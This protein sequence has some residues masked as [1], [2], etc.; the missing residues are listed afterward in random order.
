MQRR[1]RTR[2]RQ[3]AAAEDAEPPAPAPRRA[4]RARKSTVAAE[5]EPE[6]E[7]QPAGQIA[8]RASRRV[9][10]AAPEETEAQPRAP[11]RVGARGSA[12]FAPLR[13][14]QPEAPSESFVDDSTYDDPSYVTPEEPT[15]KEE[16]PQYTTHA[17][18]ERVERTAAQDTVLHLSKLNADLTK[19]LSSQQQKLQCCTLFAAVLLATVLGTLLYP[20]I[21]PS[22]ISGVIAPSPSPVADVDEAWLLHCGDE[23]LVDKWL[24]SRDPQVDCCK[25]SSSGAHECMCIRQ[26]FELWERYRSG[27]G[28]SA[29]RPEA[30][31][32][33]GAE[34][35]RTCGQ[36]MHGVHP[37]TT[38]FFRAVAQRLLNDP[39]AASDTLAAGMRAAERSL[40]PSVQQLYDR[41]GNEVIT[42]V[43]P[44]LF[45]SRLL[46]L[47]LA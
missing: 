23:G 13:T 19:Q 8:R 24:Q 33:A 39:W 21:E 9:S 22:G 14:Q 29:V 10:K 4:S 6:P 35:L 37:L 11:R 5:P 41:L 45:A 7:P 12:R 32:A 38:A 15:P 26:G 28:R 40:G 20:M 16:T 36:P 43:S 46:A 47:T 34:Y 2:G 30:D 27:E 3:P 17:P 25:R 42:L 31:R 44:A 18:I 1:T